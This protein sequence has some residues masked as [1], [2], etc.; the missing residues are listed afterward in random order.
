VR[1]RISYLTLRMSASRP[2]TLRWQ[3]G[4]PRCASPL[5]GLFPRTL[6]TY[7]RSSQSRCSDTHIDGRKLR[8]VLAC[9]R[10]FPGVLHVET[11]EHQ[12]PA[13]RLIAR[14]TSIPTFVLRAGCDVSACLLTLRG[15]INGSLNE[16]G[17][18][19]WA[20]AAWPY[21]AMGNSVI[22]HYTRRDASFCRNWPFGLQES[23]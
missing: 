7:V 19:H 20:Q 17:L 6:P 14:L 3:G 9:R 13:R 18:D 16:C 21:H 15:H 4:S 11:R 2:S 1:S 23:E 5:A 10:M 22:L 12:L 8:Q